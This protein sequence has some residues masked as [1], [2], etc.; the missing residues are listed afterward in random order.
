MSCRSEEMSSSSRSGKSTRT[1]SRSAARWV[2]TACSRKRSGA[3]SQIGVRSKKSKVLVVPISASTPA[4]VRISIA[5]GT[6]R[7]L[8]R[9]SGRLFASRITEITSATSD[10]IAATMSPTEGWSWLTRRRTRLR[11]SASA[12][13]ASRASKAAVSRRP[14]PSLCCLAPG[15]ALAGDWPSTAA[16]I[17]R[18][19]ATRFP[20]VLLDIG[21]SRIGKWGR[22]VDPSRARI[23]LE[24]CDRGVEPGERL[25]PA[26]ERERFEDP[27]GHRPARHGDPDRLEER[28]RLHVEILR[29]PAQCRLQLLLVERLCLGERRARPGQLFLSAVAGDHLR[30]GGL[31]AAQ[32][33]EG[34]PDQVVEVG[35]RLGLLLRGCDGVLEP[36]VVRPRQAGPAHPV[37]HAGGKLGRVQLADVVAVHP[38]ELLLVEHRGRARDALERELVDQLVGREEGGRLVIAP[39]E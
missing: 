26:Q 15:S 4:G 18:L 11:D 35:E 23:S 10:S 5:C 28:P 3:A 33:L 24:R 22:E 20:A 25:L 9:D 16:P 37:P 29:H 39:A 8:P 36:G 19:C 2:A 34:K 13:K 38:A 1:H 6:V 14:W 21:N 12:G 31:V 27:D 32:R 17:V 7:I 30:P